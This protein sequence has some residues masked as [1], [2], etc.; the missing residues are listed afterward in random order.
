MSG[1]LSLKNLT[2]TISGEGASGSTVICPGVGIYP[3]VT[4]NKQDIVAAEAGGFTFANWTGTAVDAGKVAN[5]NAASTT[6]VMD[7]DYTLVAN[8]VGP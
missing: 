6:V 2:V 3:F 7:A 5:A 1:D 4:N 8:F